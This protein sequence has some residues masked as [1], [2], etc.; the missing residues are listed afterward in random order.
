MKAYWRAPA[1]LHT[2]SVRLPVE[3]RLPSFG[4]ATVW[5]NSLPLTPTGLHGKVL[6][7]DFWTYTCIN[8]LLDEQPPGTAHG[9]DV[10]GQGHGTATQPRLY[11]LIRQPEPITDHTFEIT[12]LDPGAQAYAFTFG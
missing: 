2:A 4:G 1:G 12:F 7:V 11:Q 9:I 6:L 5:L 8:V 10:D 3:G